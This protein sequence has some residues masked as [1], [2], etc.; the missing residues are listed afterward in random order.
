MLLYTGRIMSLQH[1]LRAGDCPIGREH[2]HAERLALRPNRLHPAFF[3][4]GGISR[5]DV[6][7]RGSTKYKEMI[8]VP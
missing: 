3:A 8:I 7:R 6:H 5:E 4:A 2:R 1:E